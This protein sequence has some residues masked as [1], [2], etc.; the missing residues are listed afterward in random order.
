MNTIWQSCC[1]IY[2]QGKLSAQF[3]CLQLQKTNWKLAVT[4]S[5]KLNQFF[6]IFKII[7]VTD[8]S[9]PMIHDTILF[10]F[11]ETAYQ[12]FHAKP[13]CKQGKT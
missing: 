4:C 8:N 9:M 2:R 7:I 13:F 11:L 5:Y 12:R 6:N 10:V 3:P 1:D